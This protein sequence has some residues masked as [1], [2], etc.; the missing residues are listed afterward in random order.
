MY[1]VTKRHKHDFAEIDLCCLVSGVLEA[2]LPDW[3]FNMAV[4]AWLALDWA[5]SAEAPVVDLCLMQRYTAN[6]TTRPMKD[7]ITTA[8][9]DDH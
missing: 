7:S 5:A 9:M 4:S 2:V 8:K 6:T 3:L 1:R